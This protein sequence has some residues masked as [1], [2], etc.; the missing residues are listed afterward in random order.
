MPLENELLMTAFI[1][2][3]WAVEKVGDKYGV[4]PVIS[5]IVVGMIMGPALLDIVPFEEGLELIGS[6]GIM[7]LV[8]ESSLGLD[9]VMLKDN[10]ARSI[11]MGTTGVIVP[12]LFTIATYEFIFAATAPFKVALSLGIV[13]APTSLGF[14]A[15]ILGDADIL[16]TR[17][18]I[19]ICT[20]AVVDDVISLCLLGEIE[21]LKRG[22]E[23]LWIPFIGFCTIIVS[24]LILTWILP[25][26]LPHIPHNWAR[27]GGLLLVLALSL[28][29]GWIGAALK[30]S[31]LVGCFVVGV[32]FSTYTPV[33]EVWDEHVE[34]IGLWMTRLFFAAGIGFV[35]PSI[36]GRFFSGEV[37]VRALLLLACAVLGKMMVG[38]YARPFTVNSFAMTGWAMSGRGEFSFLIAK[39][40]FLAG[41]ISDVD[42]YAVIWAL[43]VGSFSAPFGMKIFLRRMQNEGDNESLRKKTPGN[44]MSSAARINKTANGYGATTK[45]H[46]AESESLLPKNRRDEEN[47][48]RNIIKGVAQHAG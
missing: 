23:G 2:V 33:K 6:L 47:Q 35:I 18:G 8:V 12:I 44:E 1:L 25:Y 30:S 46:K 20:A 11:V 19:L 42:F 3:I 27:W 29:T 38:I 10:A 5:N 13:L 48:V 32:A 17:C 28:L 21:A 45:G 43:L 24:G 31:N 16:D 26:I 4:S 37:A 14:T 15:K 41:L 36:E 7:I 39:N 40:A 22:G 34:Q 9:I